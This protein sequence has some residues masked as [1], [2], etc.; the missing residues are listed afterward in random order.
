MPSNPRVL[1]ED[2]DLRF[3]GEKTP[4]LLGLSKEAMDSRVDWPGRRLRSACHL[5]ELCYALRYEEYHRGEPGVRA[6][7]I[8][9]RD[10][11]PLGRANCAHV[12]A[13]TCAGLRVPRRMTSKAPRPRHGRT[14][15]PGQRHMIQ[16]YSCP[17]RHAYEASEFLG[18]RAM[19]ARVRETAHD[20]RQHIAG[21]CCQCWSEVVNEGFR[22]GRRPWSQAMVTMS[23][24]PA[25]QSPAHVM[26]RRRQMTAILQEQKEYQTDS[27]TGIEMGIYSDC[28]GEEHQT[29]S[30]AGSEMAICP[31]CLG[32]V[33][34]EYVPI[35]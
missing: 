20:A 27:D 26:E 29:D 14:L 24:R 17:G 2:M 9:C 23:K 33:R 3:G 31:Y 13:K 11:Q 21:M 7:A 8:R 19:S 12:S 25:R 4:E 35:A 28:M 5:W 22:G 6:A 34:W 10:C 1:A 16:I 15:G 32:E 30:D 18:G